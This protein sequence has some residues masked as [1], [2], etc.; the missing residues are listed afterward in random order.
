MLK[1]S[2]QTNKNRNNKGKRRSSRDPAVSTRA[3][4][5]RT[6]GPGRRGPRLPPAGFWP[7]TPPGA[8]PSPDARGRASAAAGLTCLKQKG[9]V[10]T[11]TPTMLFTMF[12]I[13]PQLE[14]AAAVIARA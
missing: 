8:S 3:R 14:A 13:S 12:V 7:P 4:A 9:M 1:I 5:A 10:S 6:L 2:K 11:L